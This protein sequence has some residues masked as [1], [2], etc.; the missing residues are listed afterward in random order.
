MRRLLAALAL[1]LP[2]GAAGGAEWPPV[3]PLHEAPPELRLEVQWPPPGTSFDDERPVMLSG[4]AL[5]PGVA[6][7]RR[8]VVVVID[9]SESTLDAVARPEDG[10][11]LRLSEEERRGAPPGSI[12]A[13]ELEAARRL[14]RSLDPARTRVAIVTFSGAPVAWGT[15]PVVLEGLHPDARTWSPLSGDFAAVERAL[16]R[17]E[18]A[19][20]H[21]LTHMAAGVE[22]ATAELV[23]GPEALSQPD[24]SAQR[25]IVFMTDGVPTLPA[26]GDAWRNQVELFKQ[27]R[28]AASYGI[29]IHSFA[30]GNEALRGPFTVETLAQETGGSFT[31]VTDPATLPQKLPAAPIGGIERL[32]VRN[33]TAGEDALGVTLRADGSWDA[34]VRLSPGPNRIEVE[35]AARDGAVARHAIV[36]NRSQ[37]AGAP[38]ALPDHLV[39]RRREL[40]EDSLAQQREAH[41]QALVDEMQRERAQHASEAAPGEGEIGGGETAAARAERQRRELELELERTPAAT[42]SVGA[43]APASVNAPAPG[44]T[45]LP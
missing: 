25:T 34:L 12:L 27:A 33:Q 21:G 43:P 19:G 42:P 37:S 13:S 5:A 35:A 28:R 41:R 44:S 22:R 6:G 15:P 31:P 8:D 39:A 11:P 29:H 20:A 32:R 10:T 45:R 3:A 1:V 18:A 24:P 36:L 38:P 30:V 4:A 17:V 26:P 16:E 7:P 2:G 9:V 40:L 14:L 23:G